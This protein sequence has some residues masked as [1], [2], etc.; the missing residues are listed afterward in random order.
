M[1]LKVFLN[2]LVLV[3]PNEY[4]SEILLFRARFEAQFRKGITEDV[5]NL[6]KEILKRG[7]GQYAKTWVQYLLQE[8]QF[9]YDIPRIRSHY[10]KAIQYVQDDLPTISNLWI[11]FERDNGTLSSLQQCELKIS[12]Q[13]AK[14]VAS[15]PA[16]ASQEFTNPLG[17]GSDNLEKSDGLKRG[18][19]R[20]FVD[21]EGNA[22]P[23]KVR[24]SEDIVDSDT[25][26]PV[27]KVPSIPPLVAKKKVSVNSNNNSTP[28]HGESVQHDSSKD[29]RTVFLSNL[30]FTTEE[31]EIK[32]FFTD[33]GKIE[34]VRLAKDYRG[35]SKGFGYVCFASTVNFEF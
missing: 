27:F 19:K 28:H 15:L 5:A 2:I 31:N 9:G 4:I 32:Q 17:S 22:S 23:K 1:L 14:V 13:M 34:E 20:N 26:N 24:R 7:Y 6:W 25:T 35:R 11:N 16:P 21:E 8:T 18:K 3:E 10:A 33:I 29:N 12:V 30:A